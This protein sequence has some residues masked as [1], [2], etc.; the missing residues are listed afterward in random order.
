MSEQENIKIE[1]KYGTSE[2]RSW[3][4]FDGEKYIGMWMRIDRD[5][6]G[7]ITDVKIEP[8]GLIAKFS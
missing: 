6:D 4:E 2:L 7:N 5:L 1:I 8:T 3:I